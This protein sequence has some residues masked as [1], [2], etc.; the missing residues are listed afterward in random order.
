VS[1]ILSQV[2][3]DAGCSRELR[4]DGCV[5]GIWFDTTASLAEGSYMINVDG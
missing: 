2:T 1:S 5:D 4:K 3:H